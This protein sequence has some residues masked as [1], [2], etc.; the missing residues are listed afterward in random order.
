MSTN[1]SYLKRK[2]ALYAAGLTTHGVPRSPRKKLLHK[3]ERLAWKNAKD[4]CI[5]RNHPAWHNYGGRGILFHAAWVKDFDAFFEHVGPKPDGYELDRIDNSKGYEP[6]NLQWVTISDN[7]RNKR[8]SKP[9]A[10]YF[11]RN[12]D[13]RGLTE[14]AEKTGISLALIRYRIVS[15]FP[16]EL[17]ISEPG[18]MEV[19]L[20][21][22]E[23]MKKSITKLRTSTGLSMSEACKIG[24]VKLQTAYKR[25]QYGWT[26]DMACGLQ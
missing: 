11:S 19:S 24:G 2:D 7:L 18:N 3:T 21:A 15:G 6:G 20:R 13:C 1:V 9:V 10:E 16:D 4:R 8:V 17:V 25:L 5:N 23:D 12:K 26:V 14:L 22:R